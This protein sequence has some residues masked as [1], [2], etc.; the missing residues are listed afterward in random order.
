[1]AEKGSF[2]IIE[3]GYELT[4]DPAVKEP[5]KPFTI[6]LGEGR[7]IPE[8]EEA[9]LQM[10]PGESRKVTGKFPEQYDDKNLA[11]KEAN[12]ECKLVELKKKTLPEVNDAFAA[13]I[14]E[15]STL[16]SLRQDIRTNIAASKVEDQQKAQRGAIIDY[17][18]ENNPFDVP[19]SLVDQ[20]MI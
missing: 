15:G 11:G 1:K 16:L 3:I 18:I 2:A 12:F 10:A 9:F 13:Q 5:A 8:L 14:K 7:L 4:S 6:G 20:Q 19:S 17:L